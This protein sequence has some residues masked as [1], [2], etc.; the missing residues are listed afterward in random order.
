[1][2]R[3]TVDWN[4]LEQ[5]V[6]ADNSQALAARWSRGMMPFLCGQ[7]PSHAQK[8]TL[9]HVA[10]SSGS[11]AV[12]ELLTTLAP[13]LLHSRARTGA[14][15][16]NLCAEHARA[17]DCEVLRMLVRAGANLEARRKHDG[18]AAIH[19]SAAAGCAACVALLLNKA[20][21]STA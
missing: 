2:R 9:L 8:F 7:I 21:H 16:L 20:P 12:A 10:C 17:Q 11:V 18:F 5:I 19:S 15:A 1:M 3:A 4:E 6:R 13:P 14:T